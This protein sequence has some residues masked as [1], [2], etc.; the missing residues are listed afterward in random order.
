[1]SFTVLKNIYH[2]A[3]VVVFIK[4]YH[5][6]IIVA[7]QAHNQGRKNLLYCARAGKESHSL[8][9]S[10]AARLAGHEWRAC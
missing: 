5:T 7:S 9:R 4:Q 3:R 6:E 10:L 2:D 1:M 8:S